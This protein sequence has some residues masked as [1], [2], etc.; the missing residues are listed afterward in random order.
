VTHDTP[1]YDN[2]GNQSIELTPDDPRIDLIVGMILDEWYVGSAKVREAVVETL[3]GEETV[4]PTGS[5]EAS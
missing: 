4:R 1:R 3:F 5:G 2:A